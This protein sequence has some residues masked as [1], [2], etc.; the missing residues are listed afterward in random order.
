[1]T[2]ETSMELYITAITDCQAVGKLILS[3]LS[4]H[5]PLADHQKDFRKLRSTTTAPQFLSLG[6]T[7]TV[8]RTP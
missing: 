2:K 8:E 1:M 6:T 7:L 5:L 3:T 4:D